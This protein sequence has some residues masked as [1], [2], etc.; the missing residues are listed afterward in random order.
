MANMNG[1]GTSHQRHL[2]TEI[3]IIIIINI[4]DNI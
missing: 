4:P 1:I 3:L 2:W